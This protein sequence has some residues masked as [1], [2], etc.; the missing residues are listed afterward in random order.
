MMLAHP[1]GDQLVVLG[2][3]IDDD[4]HFFR[5]LSVRGLNSITQR[6]MTL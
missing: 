5:I 2:S 4:N 3:E 6:L 1:A